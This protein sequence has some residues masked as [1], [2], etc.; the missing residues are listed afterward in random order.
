MFFNKVTTYSQNT[1][2]AGPLDILT[3][4]LSEGWNRKRSMLLMISDWRAI[5]VIV[6][7]INAVKHTDKVPS[8]RCYSGDD[9]FFA[10]VSGP[11]Y[12][13]YRPR[14]FHKGLKLMC[15]IKYNEK[16]CRTDWFFSQRYLLGSRLSK[17]AAG[18]WDKLL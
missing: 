17:M 12:Y 13:F 5:A 11:Y 16:K 9:T 15:V 4:V 7:K 2:Y 18:S 3:Y 10:I 1:L 8:Y 6:K 14:R